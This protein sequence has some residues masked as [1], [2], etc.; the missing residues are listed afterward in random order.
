MLRLPTW[1]GVDVAYCP[2][3]QGKRVG[4]IFRLE[5]RPFADRKIELVK[6]FAAQTVIAIENARLSKEL[7]DRTAEVKKLNQQLEQ[8]ANQSYGPD[9][10]GARN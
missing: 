6:N 1:L 8:R 5:V 4:V 9:E 10:I 3:A 2:H 7:R